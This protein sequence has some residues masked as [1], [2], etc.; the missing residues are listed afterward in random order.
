VILS[1]TYLT[2]KAKKAHTTTPTRQQQNK[3]TIF[4]KANPTQQ[5]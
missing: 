2:W 1:A 4:E 3:Q 5:P